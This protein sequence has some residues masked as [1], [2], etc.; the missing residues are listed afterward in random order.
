MV[1]ITK[2]KRTERKKPVKKNASDQAESNPDP[3]PKIPAEAENVSTADTPDGNVETTE[4]A[5]EQAVDKEQSIVRSEPEHPYQKP[6]TSVGKGV[7]ARVDIREINW[8]THFLPN[9][10]PAAKGKEFLQHL[11]RPNPVEEHF[12]LQ[13][14]D[15]VASLEN[16]PRLTWQEYQAQ[17][18]QLTNSP[19]DEQT[20]QEK[21]H[22]A[23]EQTTEKQPAQSKEQVEEIDR[24]VENV[25]ETDAMN[26]QEYQAQ[27]KERPAQGDEQRAH[28]QQAQREPAQE[29]KQGDVRQAQ[30]GSSA[31]VQVISSFSEHSTT[32]VRN[33][34]DRQGPSPSDLQ[35]V[36]PQVD[37]D[38]VKELTSLKDLVSSL[39]SKINRI[40][41]DTYIAKHIILQFRKHLDTKIYELETNLI[42]HFADSQQNLSG[43]IAL[44]KS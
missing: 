43:D 16:T 31:L 12:M 38:T 26:Y 39:G 2:K 8:A 5:E 42:R 30:T 10:D 40:G 27:A 23:P 14:E 9:I 44:L 22:Q 34:E 33:N 1:Q 32:L 11:D 24:A 15:R 21:E 41:V 4:S 29:A 13:S 28:E 18:A 36:R 25:E 17:L 7:F 3:V 37:V 6:M 35:I 20:D 19:S